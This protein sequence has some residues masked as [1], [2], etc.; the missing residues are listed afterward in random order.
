MAV[1][2]FLKIM[3]SSQKGDNFL[4][5]VETAQ[6]L[7]SLPHV[8]VNELFRARALHAFRWGIQEQ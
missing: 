8:S 7:P 3:F 1:R 5:P 4:G 6:K 2:D